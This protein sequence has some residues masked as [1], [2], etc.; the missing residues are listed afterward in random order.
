ML[1]AAELNVFSADHLEKVSAAGRQRLGSDGV[2]ATILPAVVSFSGG[3]N[4][5]DGRAL[6]DAGCEVAI[7]TDANPGSSMVT[8]LALCAT[9]GAT[10]C[11]LSLEESLWGATRGGAK[12]MGLDDRGTLRPGER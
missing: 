10:Q 4:W 9:M 11:G 2:I 7:A 1:L 12:A 8:D 3:D 6:R 5:P